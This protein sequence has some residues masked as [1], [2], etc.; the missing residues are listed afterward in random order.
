M[1]EK[2]IRIISIVTCLFSLTSLSMQI[3][4]STEGHHLVGEF[5]NGKELRGT[6][7]T[8]SEG[9]VRYGRQCQGS[10]HFKP[11]QG[12]LNITFPHC[13]D[14]NAEIDIRMNVLESVIDNFRSASVTYRAAH[15][16]YQT[17]QG[18]IKRIQ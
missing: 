8:S 15:F 10:Y 9:D 11:L 5:P 14:L 18:T 13:S 1:G 6:V 7:V 2:M 17:K 4:L 3:S 16:N 12:K